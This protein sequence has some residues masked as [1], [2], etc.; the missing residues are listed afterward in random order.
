MRRLL[1]IAVCAYTAFLGLF[2]LLLEWKAESFWLLTVLLF[3]PPQIF[4]LPGIALAV[5]CLGLRQWRLLGVLGLSALFVLLYMHP[6]A[7]KTPPAKS[8]AVDLKLVTH[9]IGQGNRQQFLGFLNSQKPDVI[10]LQ[11]ARNRAP[12]FQRYYPDC[13]VSARGEFVC[14]SRYLIQQGKIIE[15][16]SWQGHPVMARY[17]IIVKGKSLA[18]YSVHFPTP[19]NQLSRFLG[20]RTAI[21]MFGNEELPGG[22]ATL[23]EWNAQRAE[24]Y[25][26]AAKVFASEP[27]PCLV[28][29]DFNMPD[30]GALYHHFRTNMTDAFAATG[31][32]CG[33][34]FPGGMGRIAGLLGPWLRIDQVFTGRECAPLAVRPEDGIL[35]QHRAVMFRVGF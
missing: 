1:R 6:R 32:G 33:F 19:R 10:L 28:A 21:A 9:N 34:T 20:A 31:S 27:L 14:L 22:K 2:L 13:Y 17:E 5:P 16:P 4:L 7:G 12:E 3:A 15:Q 29:G 8:G 23:H 11:D 26:A 30:H 18:L 35:S 25:R 24:L